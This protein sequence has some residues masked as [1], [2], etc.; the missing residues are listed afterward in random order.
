M[1]ADKLRARPLRTAH[2]S[3]CWDQLLIAPLWV[4]YDVNLGTLLRTCDAIGACMAV[5]NTPHYRRCLARGDT[6]ARCP[7]VHWIGPTQG[8]WV[9][10]QQSAGTR[11]VAVEVADGSVP[12]AQLEPTHERTVV[13]L[14]HERHGIPP[15]VIRCADTC[16]EIPMRGVGHSLNV[17]VAGSLVGYRLAGLA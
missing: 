11:I 9:R 10:D 15:D 16:V 4:A 14:G 13:L 2:G 5:P 3:R 17:A 1:S 6:L 8:E 12:L 7:C